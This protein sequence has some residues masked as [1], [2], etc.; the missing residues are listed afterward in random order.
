MFF[1]LMTAHSSAAAAWVWQ[2]GAERGLPSGTD[3]SLAHAD[4]R[5]PAGMR[6]GLFLKKISENFH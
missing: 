1:F 4:T 5:T 2:H 3:K 6:H